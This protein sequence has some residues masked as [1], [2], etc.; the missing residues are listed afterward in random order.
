MGNIK[1]ILLKFYEFSI[2]LQ[3]NVNFNANIIKYD[4]KNMR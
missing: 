4:T 2:P 3:F 1:E